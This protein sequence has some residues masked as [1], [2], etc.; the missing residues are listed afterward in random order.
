MPSWAMGEGLVMVAVCLPIYRAHRNNLVRLEH[1]RD[2]HVTPPL[3]RDLV[4]YRWV[5]HRLEPPAVHVLLHIELVQDGRV[6]RTLTGHHARLKETDVLHSQPH[7][8]MGVLLAVVKAFLD[9]LEIDNCG[10]YE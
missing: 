10:M 2:M 7:K 6:E 3:K 5:A 1:R 9:L 4:D 8:M